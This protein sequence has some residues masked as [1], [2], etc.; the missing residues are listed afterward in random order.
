MGFIKDRSFHQV[1]AT[2]GCGGA[3]RRW[4]VV[5]GGIMGRSCTT[6]RMGCPIACG[7]LILVMRAHLD[8]LDH[9][10]VGCGL[11]LVEADA[12]NRE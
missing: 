7:H 10:S 11:D 4:R 2:I 6:T 3:E 9:G 1:V 8:A 12:D 5:A